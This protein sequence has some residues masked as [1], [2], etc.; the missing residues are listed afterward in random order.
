[1]TSQKGLPSVVRTVTIT[2]TRSVEHMLRQDRLVK[3]LW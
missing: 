3:S 2:G 1:M